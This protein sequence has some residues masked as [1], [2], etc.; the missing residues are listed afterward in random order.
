MLSRKSMQVTGGVASLVAFVVGLALGG[1]LRWREPDWTLIEHF[2]TSL[3]ASL[4]WP[5]AVTTSVYLLRSQIEELLRRLVKYEG[6]GHKVEFKAAVEALTE[7]LEESAEPVP[8]GTMLSNPPS[9]AQRLNALAETSPTNAVLAAWGELLEAANQTLARL[10]GTSRETGAG[11]ATDLIRRH[12]LDESDRAA[13]ETLRI[14][15]NVAAHPTPSISAPSVDDARG[16][17]RR[18]LE[19]IAKLNAVQPG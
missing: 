6:Y 7:S 4:A 5:I 10:G 18:A 19:L 9:L 8:L 14:I 16:F 17:V 13:F 1:L 12:A 11:L 15:R 3:A 2:I